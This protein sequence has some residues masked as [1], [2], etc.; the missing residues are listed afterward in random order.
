MHALVLAVA[1]AMPLQ[2]VATARELVEPTRAPGK[3]GE[4]ED[5]AT[6]TLQV[7]HGH[8]RDG[9]YEAALTAYRK[10]EERYW[11]GKTRAKY[12]CGNNDPRSE[13]MPY[14]L[15]QGISLE[16]LGRID[17]AMGVYASVLLDAPRS[18][19]RPL[20]LHLIE[21][22]DAA[23]RLDV[24]ER[25]LD[26]AEKAPL[27]DW[28]SPLPI[29]RVAPQA[30]ADGIRAILDVHRL[31]KQGDWRSLVAVLE[32]WDRNPSSFGVTGAVIDK[33]RA[34][35][36]ALARHCDEALPLLPSAASDP[37]AEMRPWAKYTRDLCGGGRVVHR[38]SP[39]DY[40]NPDRPEVD[41]PRVARGELPDPI[42]CAPRRAHTT[43]P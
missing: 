12:F 6:A 35:A 29:S 2:G 26:G 38:P 10:A 3:P 5:G 41:L 8:F 33:P 20:A 19:R 28:T 22:Y 13:V 15:Y 21:M 31:E 11:E 1:L 27:L 42:V 39:R 37:G 32:T 30:Q 16:R 17:D 40:D 23:G 24:L 18:W 14:V 43:C 34:A 4:A 36:H 25:F 9:Q 7:G